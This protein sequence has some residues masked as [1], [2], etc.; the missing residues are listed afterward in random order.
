MG[1]VYILGDLNVK[2]NGQRLISIVTDKQF[3]LFEHFLNEFK[4]VSLPLQPFGVGS[5][6]TF[7]SYEDGSTT[8]I[9]HIL[10]SND[11]ICQVNSGRVLDYHSFNVSDHHSII[12]EVKTDQNMDVES[13]NNTNIRLS[14][15]GKSKTAE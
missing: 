10:L 1:T 5:P 12:V 9:D 14:S 3:E 8:Y 15:V 13:E 6:Y 4:L 2:V 11:Y 7:Q